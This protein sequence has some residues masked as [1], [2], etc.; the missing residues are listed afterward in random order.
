MK[1]AKRPKRCA[2]C[3]KALR[4]HNKTGYCSICYERCHSRGKY[5]HDKCKCGEFK[6]KTSK[7]CK[8]C[9]FKHWV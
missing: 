8:K 3:K 7:V 6:L 2:N 1:T 4:A 5:R 9:W